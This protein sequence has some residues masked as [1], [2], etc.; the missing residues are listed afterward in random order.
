MRRL[1][2]TDHKC[3]SHDASGRIKERDALEKLKER[4]RFPTIKQ[5]RAR[6]HDKMRTIAIPMA[7]TLKDY[8]RYNQSL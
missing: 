7:P 4:G 8:P 2:S 6:A 5:P 3:S 1:V